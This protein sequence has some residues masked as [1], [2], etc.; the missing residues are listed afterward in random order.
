MGCMSVTHQRVLDFHTARQSRDPEIIASF[1][2][3]DVEWS[4]AGPVDLIPF[5]G[6]RFGK[7]AAID[8]MVRLAPSLFTVTKLEHETI[9]VD[10]DR[11]AGCNKLTAV[12][13]STGRILSYRRAEFFVFRDD[14]IV[15]Y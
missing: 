14:K 9:I 15:S 10:G 12:Q 1:L 2:H 3:D 7:N 8:A 4:I 6:Q 13:K 11:A 5:C